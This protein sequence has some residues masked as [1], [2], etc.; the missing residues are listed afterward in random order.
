MTFT[1]VLF[2]VVLVG[3]AIGVVGVAILLFAF[4]AFGKPFRAN[5]LIAVLLAFVL[6]CCLAL[7]RL[8]LMK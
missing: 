3:S 5:V 8:S 4:R 7:L 6:V 1:T 2:R